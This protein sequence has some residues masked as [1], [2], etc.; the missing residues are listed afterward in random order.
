L[1]LS[2][3]QPTQALAE[4]ETVLTVAPNRFNALYGAA[5]AAEAAG[6]PVS[7]G[8]YFKKLTESAVGEERP[9]LATARKKVTIASK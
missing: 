4:Y 6:N 7:A 8:N 5:M 9:E 2:Q 3:K 1:L